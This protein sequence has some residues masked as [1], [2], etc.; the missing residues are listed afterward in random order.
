M[1]SDRGWRP[2]CGSASP[3]PFSGRLPLTSIGGVSTYQFEHAL[4]PLPA[5][6]TSKRC[7]RQASLHSLYTPSTTTILVVENL[8]SSSLM[9]A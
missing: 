8:L 4:N 1:R 2:S 3:D 5:D 7:M 6:D 9:S